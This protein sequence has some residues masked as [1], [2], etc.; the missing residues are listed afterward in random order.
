MHNNS[1]GFVYHHIG[2][3]HTHG[4]PMENQR[5]LYS[6]VPFYHHIAS[7]DFVIYSPVYMDI[8]NRFRNHFS[9]HM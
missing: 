4:E 6:L 7:N 8:L 1:L 5:M 3:V 2:Y 9:L